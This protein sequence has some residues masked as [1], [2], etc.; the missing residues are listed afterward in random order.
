MTRLQILQY[1]H[2]AK[3]FLD[4]ARIVVDARA[5]DPFTRAPVLHLIAHSLELQFKYCLLASGV[6]PSVVREFGHDLSRLWNDCHVSRCRLLAYGSARHAWANASQNPLYGDEFGEDPVA[7]L[8]DHIDSLSR[9]HTSGS[10]FA[11]RYPGEPDE[12]GPVPLL[13][14]DTFEPIVADLQRLH[15]TRDQVAA[16]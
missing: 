15:L 12:R 11:L 6:P 16:S 10:D 1:L 9:L 7:V 4:A 14:L 8:D 5:N 2:R 3:G 13:L